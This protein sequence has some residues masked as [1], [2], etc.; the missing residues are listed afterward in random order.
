MKD[1]TALDRLAE[2]LGYSP[3]AT[4][5]LVVG[6]SL[7]VIAIWVMACFALSRYTVPAQEVQPRRR[8]AR[9]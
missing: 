5:A 3:N 9:S 2:Y 6:T 1:T 4:I 8:G 7:V